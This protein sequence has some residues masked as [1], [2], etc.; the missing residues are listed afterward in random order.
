[1]RNHSF[2]FWVVLALLVDGVLVAVTDEV[3]PVSVMKGDSVILNTGVSELQSDNTIEWIFGDKLIIA[4]MEGKKI[5]I[6]V[7]RD[8]L[9]LEN[10]NGS[11]IIK[12]ITN[13]QEG[14]YKV[15][16]RGRYETSKRFN[17]TVRDVVESV[18]VTEGDTVTL[19]TG[20]TK[21]QRADQILWKFGDQVLNTDLNGLNNPVNARWSNIDLN[22]QT[23]EITIRNIQRD[24]AGVYILE[25]NTSIMILHRKLCITVEAMKTVSVK[26][27]ESVTL[28]TGVIEIQG[29]DLIKWKFEEHLIAE[30]NQGTNL[31]ILEDSSDERFKGRL[32]LSEKSG[33]LTISDSETTDSGVYHL[34][35]I[36]SSHTVQRTISVTVKA[37]IPDNHTPDSGLH[38]GYVALIS[39]IVLVMLVAAVTLVICYRTRN[40]TSEFI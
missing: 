38:P 29:Y 3:K 2:P 21:K 6:I 16:I 39:V 34:N 40:Q 30:I 26:K 25:I 1:M 8:K 13:E 32:Q 20:V 4:K 28:H 17:V 19:H 10:E 7:F 23:G 18:S 33:S 27:G 36:S 31:F 12:D 11:L 22:D 37:F 5:S 14:L 15:D 35:M 9:N 24:Q